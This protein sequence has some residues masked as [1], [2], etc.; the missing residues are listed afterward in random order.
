MLHLIHDVIWKSVQAWNWDVIHAAVAE[1]K[2]RRRTLPQNRLAKTTGSR[3]PPASGEGPLHERQG[4]HPPTPREMPAAQVRDGPTKVSR[5]WLAY[6]QQL[7]RLERR[8]IRSFRVPPS[9]APGLPAHA[10]AV[11]MLGLVRRPVYRT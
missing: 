5:G 7:G 8:Q 2:Q 11:Q 9:S 6:S 3:F 4:A 10:P 1:G